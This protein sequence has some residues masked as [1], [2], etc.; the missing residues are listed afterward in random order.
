MNLSKHLPKLAIALVLVGG[1]AVIASKFS[2]SS[3][4][5]GMVD[6]KVPELSKGAAKGKQLF[7]DNCASCHGPNASGGKGGPPLIHNI[8]NPGHHDDGS[9][10]RA[11]KNGVPGHHWQ[12]GNMPPQP[13][14]NPGQ[15]AEMIVYVREVQMANGIFYQEH[16]MQ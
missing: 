12:F 4:G 5:G 15:M 16:K 13:Q 10:Q 7:D 2:T 14:I 6:V 1:V 9:F 11:A 3:G 8:Y